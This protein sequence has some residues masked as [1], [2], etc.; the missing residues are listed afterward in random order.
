MKRMAVLDITLCQ[1]VLEA[2][3]KLNS[4]I[5]SEFALQV[6]CSLS[7]ETVSISL[8]KDGIALHAYPN[9]PV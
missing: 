7:R 1:S 9:L 6:L 2:A 4:F 3:T 8:D 5:A